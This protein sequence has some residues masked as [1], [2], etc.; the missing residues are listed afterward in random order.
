MIKTLIKGLITLFALL[1]ISHV[2]AETQLNGFLSAQFGMSAEEVQANFKTDEVIF[3]SSEITDND[4]LIYAQRKQDWITSELLYVFP[5]GSDR[6][7]LVIE[8]F[9]GLLDT[10][11]IRKELTEKLGQPSSENYPEPV[12]NHMQESNV[13]PAGVNQLTVWNVTAEDIDREAR[14]MGLNEYVRVEYI[15]NDLMAGK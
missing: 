10:T 1:N 5:A 11:P 9:P 7:A 4:H 3:S 13:I 6:L 2:L 15:D 14:I 12:L 8:I